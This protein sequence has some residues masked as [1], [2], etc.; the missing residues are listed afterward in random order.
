MQAPDQFSASIQGACLIVS[1]QV[2][3]VQSRFFN[4]VTNDYFSPASATAGSATD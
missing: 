3:T 4:K 2:M 1:Q